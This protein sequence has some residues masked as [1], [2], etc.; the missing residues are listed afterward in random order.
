MIIWVKGTLHEGKKG[1]K[2]L[3]YTKDIYQNA[4][5]SYLFVIGLGGYFYLLCI[6][7]LSNIFKLTN[8][9]YNKWL[10]S[11]LKND[12]IQR[13]KLFPIKILMFFGS[14]WKEKI[15]QSKKWTRHFNP[16]LFCI[17]QRSKKK[18]QN[19]NQGKWSLEDFKLEK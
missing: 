10:S 7:I 5:Y 12:I 8:C 4:N 19:R 17:M 13:E 18:R 1:T 2:N 11:V 16:N 15:E 14:G 9:F 6:F 3:M